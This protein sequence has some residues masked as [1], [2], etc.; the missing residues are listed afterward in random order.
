KRAEAKQERLYPPLPGGCKTIP[1]WRKGSPVC[2]IFSVIVSGSDNGW[3][4]LSIGTALSPRPSRFSK[5]AAHMF[6]TSRRPLAPRIRLRVE[7]PESRGLLS[8]DPFSAGPV[9]GANGSVAAS[10]LL[11]PS[12]IASTAITLAVIS[13]DGL[14]LGYITSLAVNPSGTRVYLGRAGSS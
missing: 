12:T 8:V 4:C 10:S 13:R 7:P 9:L 1:I 6:R 5:G 3:L 14:G 2:V 11:D